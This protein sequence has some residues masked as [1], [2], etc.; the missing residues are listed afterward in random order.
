MLD[1]ME[2]TKSKEIG[3]RKQ[4]KDKDGGSSCQKRGEFKTL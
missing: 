3:G 1:Y 4:G 2:E